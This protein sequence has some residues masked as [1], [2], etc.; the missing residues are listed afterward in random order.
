MA[1]PEQIAAQAAEDAKNIPPA[2]ARASAKIATDIAARNA[3]KTTLTP[4]PAPT[5]QS[6]PEPVQH[7]VPAPTPQSNP[8]PE[9]W[10]H[11]YNSMKGRADQEAARNRELQERLASQQRL[12]AI[13]E[14]A[15]QP[16]PQ[17]APTNARL[18][19]PM[20]ETEYGVEMLDVVGRR[21]REIVTPEMA[22]LRAEIAELK[23]QIGGVNNVVAQSARDKFFSDMDAQMPG[24]RTQNEDPQF[25][26]WLDLPDPYSGAIRSNLLR[27]AFAGYDLARVQS[28]FKGFLSHE[29]APRPA[30]VPVVAATGARAPELSLENLAAPGRARQSGSAQLPA[31]KQIYT[32]ADIKQFYKDTN[33]GAWAGREPER[34]AME[35][36]IFRAQNEGRIR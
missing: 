15:P 13:M 21:A 22:T 16:A 36:D 20:E 23:R 30:E 1:T 35:R 11:R 7:P 9:N 3:A 24:W 6:N 5:P 17:P 28:F 34:L 2:V 10:E 4:A 8:E 14:A 33:S 19:T 32:R 31:E 27:Q 25:L 12:L 26:S 29:A 18:I